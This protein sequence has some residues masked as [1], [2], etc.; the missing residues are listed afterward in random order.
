MHEFPAGRSRFFKDMMKVR[1]SKI[2]IFLLVLFCSVSAVWG[3]AIVWE[4]NNSADWTDDY[5][6]I[7]NT[8]P[9]SGD[10]VEII[11]GT[12]HNPEIF[13]SAV[14]NVNN[15]T[16]NS[17]GNLTVSEDI[18]V[19]GNIGGD[20]SGILTLSNGIELA[21]GGTWAY[22]GTLN[23]A[24]S[25][26][27]FTGTGK[28]I[29]SYGESFDE[30]IIAG[31]YTQS[32]T[33][34]GTTLNIASG[35]VH[36]ANGNPISG[37]IHNQG[38]LQLVGNETLGSLN[39]DAGE[40]EFTG[41]SSN[42]SGKTS[43]YDLTISNSSRVAASSL[44]INHNLSVSGGNLQLNV[45]GNTVTGTTTV[46]PGRI[47]QISEGTTLTGAVSGAG[48]VTI[49]SGK[50]LTA[51]GNW[52][53]TTVDAGYGSIL[54]LNGSGTFNANGNSFQN[55]TVNGSYIFNDDVTLVNLTNNGTLNISG[56]TITATE[57]VLLNN[58]AGNVTANGSSIS[59]VTFTQNGKT[60]SSSGNLTL[61]VSGSAL[62]NG[63]SI[64]A[65]AGSLILEGSG[66][67]TLT[68]LNAVGILHTNGFSTGAIN[69]SN[70]T[71]IIV[72]TG[73]NGIN[74]SNMPVSL[75]VDSGQ[76]TLANNISTGGGNVDFNN[77]VILS[78]SVT[79]TSSGGAV[80][81]SGTVDGGNNLTIVSG[82]GNV[83][84][85]G[86]V[87]AGTVIGTGTGSALT[88][89]NTTGI[90]TFTGTL[91]TANGINISGPAEFKN[92][93]NINAGTVD[94]NFGN[95]VDFTAS[96]DVSF[97]SAGKIIFNDDVSSTQNITIQSTQINL[98]GKK[99]STTADKNITLVIDGL[100]SAGSIDA[101]TGIFTM[102]PIN[103]GDSIEYGDSRIILPPTNV[104]Y[105]SD[106]IDIT[107]GSFIIGE[108]THEGNIYISGV[109]DAKSALTIRNRTSD[110]IIYIQG[111]YASAGKSLTLTT[112][113]VSISN[114][115][116]R[117]ISLGSSALSINAPVEMNDSLTVTAT[118]TGGISF[119]ST[120]S[121]DVPGR[122]LTLNGGD[123][124]VPGAVGTGTALGDIIV[125]SGAIVSFSSVN[126]A[127]FTQ[128]GTGT[129]TFGGTQ[130]YSGDF[131][132]TGNNMTTTT[133]ASLTTTNGGDFSFT[134][135]SL[136]INNSLTVAGTTT[137]TSSSTF[138]KGT[139]GAISSGS[140]FEQK[141]SGTNSIGNNI[142]VTT[143]GE[144][145][146]FTSQLTISPAN[147]NTVTFKTMGGLINLK[148]T[149][150]LSS[151]GTDRSLTLNTDTGAGNIN[152]A[153]AVNL[154]GSLS[155]SAGTGDISIAGTV[156]LT[157]SLSVNDLDS[158]ASFTVNGNSITAATGITQT[159]T[160]ANIIYGTISTANSAISFAGP[161][162]NGGVNT[163]TISMT[164]GTGTVTAAA[165][166]AASSN[167]FNGI[168][169]TGSDINLNGNIYSEDDII[170]TGLGMV[171]VASTGGIFAEDTITVTGTGITAINTSGTIAAQ[172]LLTMYGNVTNSG[173]IKSGQLGSSSDSMIFNDNYTGNGSGRLIGNA[174]ASADPNIIFKGSVTFNSGGITQ[175][176][177]VIKFEGSSAQTF[178]PG[179]NL[180]AGDIIINNGNGVTVSGSKGA[181]NGNLALY[182]GGFTIA[183][184]YAWLMDTSNASLPSVTG[185]SGDSGT[186]ILGD[187][188]NQVTSLTAPGFTTSSSFTFTAAGTGTKTIT[189]S[190]N[191][192]FDDGTNITS[193]S[194]LSSVDFVMS[195]TGS[196]SFKINSA[197]SSDWQIGSLTVS[198][199]NVTLGAPL[200]AKND[201]SIL[202]GTL[203]VP[204][205]LYTITLGR[206]WYQYDAEVFDPGT[207]KVEF[208]A[209]NAPLDLVSGNPAIKIQGS[210]KWYDFLCDTASGVTIK[211]ARNNSDTTKDVE[212]VFAH[213]F[214]VKAASGETLLTKM[215]D[216]DYRLG[217]TPPVG[218]NLKP[219]SPPEANERWYF[220]NINVDITNPSVTVELKNVV[221]NYSWADPYQ[222]LLRGDK[223]DN[224]IAS[225]YADPNGHFCVGWT[226]GISFLYSYTEDT[227]HN[228][229]IDRIRVQATAPFYGVFDS[230]FKIEVDG[231]KVKKYERNPSYAN[232]FY[233]I[234][235]EN[236]YADGGNTPTWNLI[237]NETIVDAET[238]QIPFT[239]ITSE[240]PTVNTTWPI[241][242]YS[243]I[244]P[245]SG[246]PS[247]KQQLYIQFSEPVFAFTASN[248]VYNGGLFTGNTITSMSGNGLGY[249]SEYLVEFLPTNE[250]TIADMAAE[251]TYTITSLDLEDYKNPIPP[252]TIYSESPPVYPSSDSY[253]NY[254]LSNNSPAEVQ[255]KT[256]R[257]TDV[258][259]SIPPVNDSDNRY[260]A[261]PFLAMDKM[262]Y[263]E[264]FKSIDQDRDRV[265]ITKFD[266]SGTLRD[267]D[268]TLDVLV[269]PNF[270]T[271]S[272]DLIA[273]ISV[274]SSFRGTSTYGSSGLWLTYPVYP[275]VL[276]GLAPKAFTSIKRY[277]AVPSSKRASYTLSENDYGNNDV[278][279][280]YFT[281]SG[282]ADLLAGRLDIAADAAVPFDWY[283]RIKPFTFSVKEM[284]LQRG[285]ATIL[286]NVI[287][288]TKGEK[289]YLNYTLNKSGQ[290]TVQVFTM[291]G[292]LV[293]VL[294]RG[295]RSAGEYVESWDGKN[296]GGRA[297][298]RGMYFIRIVGPD[299]DEIRK[300]M[301]IK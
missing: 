207:S 237:S 140:I 150:D 25:T 64:S 277:T 159:G 112:S 229:R 75:S 76:I 265:V 151:A 243:L 115:A 170:I 17:S 260:F 231:Y 119:S 155:M 281:T 194:N 152:I 215:Q 41:S 49:D 224:V 248:I 235:E 117:T 196:T 31:T 89:N 132:F 163:R 206:N 250:V 84:F 247:V 199:G 77:D 95:T 158:T 52:N 105:S 2:C 73:A 220:W 48:T 100:L 79:I 63:G 252:F 70:S 62:Q 295:S 135:A 19:D 51:E 227:D 98:N 34:T 187:A 157:R 120:I 249:Y 14:V 184:S 53:V 254:N 138:T 83:G 85:D 298:A 57:T 175:N 23:A 97:T 37:A 15:I 60:I 38:K 99:I 54:Q 81:F 283:C 1:T 134:G 125:G 255:N 267:T 294:Y 162:T 195:G 256:S 92:T 86:S 43:F 136:T 291:D 168:T 58:T 124:T 186:L 288:P 245:Y 274:P 20:G 212:H 226:K 272:L 88:I 72:G 259:I 213:S 102:R 174:T 240:M 110:G 234:L 161:I 107:A 4:G 241:I 222:I 181:Q 169:I 46:S 139:I 292:T 129:T 299:I 128:T 160:G 191:V 133:A 142:T 301:I 68:E 172:A 69:F 228:G 179:G 209:A 276:P 232:M 173:T 106:W 7:G 200:S 223:F 289:T 121:A 219:S 296:R 82:A 44:T 91:T 114:G 278:V 156:N 87:G 239:T 101:G 205:A 269:N 16:I 287:N 146:I 261:W 28:N 236:P 264:P 171:T 182:N 8:A 35:A 177:D 143:S 131:S 300:V 214:L 246:D 230:S 218:G 22:S 11:G 45:N 18:T 104:Y 71:G 286:N 266:G 185:F 27:R 111:N 145:L 244:L 40:V 21:V 78:S 33:L 80:T 280:F 203:A 109:A 198:G 26:V 29:A 154:T 94:T 90:A 123:I 118:G 192:T 201:I 221:V 253:S 216:S 74:T 47:I 5:N 211:F 67:Y 275:D 13:P 282:S 113:K 9:Q 210:T 188:T 164:A 258:L 153:G 6:W 147:N 39:D 262:A 293:Q 165:I 24:G 12:P 65:A 273:G 30:V 270:S 93:V 202:A 268:I 141:G 271:T 59:A 36:N 108:S 178:S 148:S 189:S 144:S 242:N 32:D 285:G 263:I 251:K 61:A 233:I 126:A 190:G 238:K 180:F 50:T 204:N 225:P 66:S 10:D 197:I 127:S 284:T 176:S 96:S 116:S 103:P 208:T 257:I 122:S 183:S 130:A 290:V 167:G 166:G 42:L 56:R 279:D 137:I 3:Q 193:S 297:V 149:S 55:I 217:T